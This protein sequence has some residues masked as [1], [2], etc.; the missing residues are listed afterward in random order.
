MPR[1]SQPIRRRSRTPLVIGGFIA[2]VVVA[3]VAA[4]VIAGG[5]PPGAAEPAAQVT[6]GGEPLP[7][8]TNPAADAA[9]GRPVP[10]LSGIGLDG[11]PIAIGPGDGAMAIVVLAHWCPHCQAELPGIVQLIEQGGVP[12]GVSIVGLST[13]IDAV[14]PN[15]PP[16]AWFEREGWTQ[17]TLIDDAGSSALDALGLGSFPG[18]VFVDGQGVVVQRLT[19]E[20]GAE[21]FGELLASIAP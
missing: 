18:F 7:A 4:G 5:A 16:S 12:E 21:Q 8:L 10:T 9:V 3:A 1:R 11:R 17:P 14:R 15:Y 13:G 2:I 6:I 20:I 19:G